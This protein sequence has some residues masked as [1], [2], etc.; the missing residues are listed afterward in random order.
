MADPSIRPAALNMSGS[1]GSLGSGHSPHAWPILAISFITFVVIYGVWYSYS[2]FLVALIQEFG[3]SRSLVS[4]GFAF[5]SLVNGVVAPLTGPTRSSRPMTNPASK[6]P[7]WAQLS[8]KG[9]KRPFS[10]WYAAM[11]PMVTP[12]RRSREPC[13]A[14]R[15]WK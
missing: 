8:T 3:W 11:T 5:F 6:P 10:N 4:G 7:A 1:V 13:F 15:R 12:M 2:V 14:R 9:D